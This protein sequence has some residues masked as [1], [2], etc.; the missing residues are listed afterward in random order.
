MPSGKKQT[1]LTSLKSLKANVD[2]IE[3]PPLPTLVHDKAF[4]DDIAGRGFHNGVLDGLRGFY[5]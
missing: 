5:A 1:A 2:K 3:L 4:F